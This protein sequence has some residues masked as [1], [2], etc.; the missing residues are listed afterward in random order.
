MFKLN[1]KTRRVVAL[2]FFAIIGFITISATTAVSQRIFTIGDSTVQDYNAGYAPRKGWGQV[3]QSF[4]SSADVQVVNRAVGGTSSRSFYNSFW[5]GVKGEMKRGDFL[6]IQFGINDRAADA[7]RRA[8]GED[9]KNF[10]RSYVNEARAMGVIPV[11]VSTVRRDAWQNG[12]PYDSYHEHPGLVR[13]VAAELKVPLIDLDAKEKAGMIAATQAYTGRYWSNTYVAGEYP[14]YQNGNTD[15]VHFQEMGA[16]QLAKYVIEEIQKLGANSLVAS[17]IPFIKQQYPVTVRA[18]H[19]EAGLITRT[20]TYPSGLNLHMKAIPYNGHRFLNWKDG[21]NN[22][23]SSGNIYQFTMG[24]AARTFVAYFDDEISIISDCNGVVNGNAILDNCGICT[25]GTTGKTA[26]TTSVQAENACLAD[27][28]V[29]E[30]I[31]TG[32]LGTGYVNIDNAVGSKILLNVASLTAINT[33]VSFRYANGGATARS[34]SVKLNDATVSNLNFTPTASFTS[35]SSET[36]NL[37]LKVGSNLIELTSLTS[38]GGPNIDLLSFNIDGISVGSCGQDCSGKMFGTAYL[39]SCNTCVGGTTGKV[40]CTKDCSGQW[41]GNSLVDNC[42]ICVSSQALAC[43]G[44]IQ[45][46]EACSVDGIL[47]ES[48][49]VGFVGEGYVNTNNVIDAS[50]TYNFLTNTPLNSIV[51]TVR[52]ANGGTTNRN[53]NLMVGGLASGMV[54]FAPTGSW[55]TW[56]TT[57]FNLNTKTEINE[58]KLIANS[59]EGLPNIDLFAWNNDNVV[60]GTCLVTNIA[61][62]S[63]LPEIRG[64]NPFTTHTIISL[65]KNFNYSLSTVSGQLIN[66]GVAEKELEIGEQLASGIYILQIELESKVHFIRLIKR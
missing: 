66:S 27:G 1:K 6:F 19:P 65:N 29:S 46:E 41:G 18:N 17:L 51:V 62:A 9:F 56:G 47:L 64:A 30:T 37:N 3:L 23:I 11:L 36:I 59:D 5:S 7:A 43:T 8:V 31:N 21:N 12:V 60:G 38:D 54:T 49:N 26:C 55:E 13:E 20:E 14:N 34:M 48:T 2:L 33:P 61:S 45:G 39:D 40:A 35:W 15:Q 32:F 28:D 53:A 50:I 16:I 24:A 4:F 42:G 52:Y 57:Q 22:L 58:V 63:N 10:L 25:G 44:S